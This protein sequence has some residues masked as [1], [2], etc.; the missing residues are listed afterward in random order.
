MPAQPGILA[1]APRPARLLTFR[2]PP[3]AHRR[4]RFLTSLPPPGPA[5]GPALA[6]L[7]APPLPGGAIVGLGGELAGT[8]IAG[9]RPPPPLVGPGVCVPATGAALWVRLVDADRG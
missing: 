8:A 4:A 5:A 2:L 3:G 7:A 1:P 6:T 9:L